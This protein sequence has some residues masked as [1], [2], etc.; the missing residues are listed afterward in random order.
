[1][2]HQDETKRGLPCYSLI[3]INICSLSGSLEKNL[4]MFVLVTTT[5]VSLMEKFIQLP[6]ILFVMTKDFSFF[7]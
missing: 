2:Q 6:N 1:M 4:M 5:E 7:L 3:L